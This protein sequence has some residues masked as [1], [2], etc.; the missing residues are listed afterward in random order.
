M[1]AA[2]KKDAVIVRV[3]LEFL[4]GHHDRQGVMCA[5]LEHLAGQPASSRSR[6]TAQLVLDYLEHE[7]PLHIADEEEDLFPLLRERCGRD[8]DLETMFAMLRSE[9]GSD[10]ALMARLMG[11]LRDLASGR[12][13]AAPDVFARDAM[14]FATL[15]RRHLAWENGTILPLAR[16]RLSAED[17]A[18]LGRRMTARRGGDQRS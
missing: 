5:G 13:P 10:D 7:L 11:P 17:K 1:D 18:E 14:A 3:P 9:H 6:E 15:Q 12:T 2:T 4:A 8:D 16:Q